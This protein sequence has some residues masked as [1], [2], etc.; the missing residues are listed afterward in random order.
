MTRTAVVLF[1]LGGPD[2]PSAVR[3]FLFNLFNDPAIVTFPAPLRWPLAQAIAARRAPTARAIYDK[4]GGA[5]PLL[6]NTEAQ[7]RAL[8]AALGAGYRVFIAMRYWHP[9]S[10]AAAAE[11]RDYDPE[12][13]V[14]L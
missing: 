1:N 3:P 7:A 5:S 12:E 6:P 8:E 13:I 2:S 10:R 11:V 9:Q 4:I 14:L